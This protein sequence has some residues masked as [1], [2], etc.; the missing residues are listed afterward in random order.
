MA[1]LLG[2]ALAVGVLRVRNVYLVSALI[3]LGLALIGTLMVV[4]FGLDNIANLRRVVTAAAN[5]GH[6]LRPPAQFTAGWAAILGWIMATIGF[7]AAWA[8]TAARRRSIGVLLPMPLAAIAGI[9][10][11][12]HDAQ[13]AS[14]LVVVVLFAAALGVLSSAQL[15]SGEGQVSR[16]YELR[17][18]LKAL[19]VLAG[20]TVALFFI[21]TQATFLFPHP[22]IDPNLEPQKPKAVPLSVVTDRVLF[23]A[24]DPSGSAL[25]VTGPWVLGRL[26]V[27]DGQDWRLAPFASRSVKAVDKSGIVDKSLTPGIK[28]Q[29]TIKGLDGTVLPGLPNLYGIAAQGPALTYDKRTGVVRLVEG[30]V[31]PDLKY[32]DVAAAIPTVESLKALGD[33]PHFPHEFDEF[34]TIPAPPPAVV[35]LINKAPSAS[36]WEQFDYLRNYV[37]QNVTATGTGTPVSVPP[38]RVQDMLAGSKEGS[39]YELVAAQ[40]M[41]ARWVGVPSRIGYGFD[42][43]EKVGNT[44]E[45]HPKNGVAFPEVYFPGFGWLPIIGTPVHAR[46]TQGSNN[47][48]TNIAAFPSDDTTVPLYVPTLTNVPVPFFEVVRQVVIAVVPLVLLVLLVYFTF[49]GLQKTVLRLRRRAV[50]RKAG[51]RARLVLAYSEWRDYATDF[52]YPFPSD[53]P[54]MFVDRF[55][56][57]HEHAELA[58]L[59]TRGLWGDLREEMTPALATDAEQLSRALRRRLALAQ[60]ITVRAVAFVSRLSL[61]RPYNADSA[62]GKAASKRRGLTLE[63]KGAHA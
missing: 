58:W 60:P 2:V 50:A 46:V 34:T 54:L 53:T 12:E 56:P 48:Q 21:A 16:A 24:S 27:Y 57:D 43:G 40:A 18:A 35:S 31:Q 13:I 20:S 36:K 15:A 29:I 26:D 25:D 55:V 33:K 10:I 4:P 37:L 38:S 51:P 41:L 3:L 47:V 30:Q 1:G 9:S 45:V 7:G 8:A 22:V 52:G 49:P 11:R 44:L 32:T 28:V 62:P 19:P 42:S 14:G 6:T 5:S 17:R 59:V 39:P 23:V 63:V 61:R